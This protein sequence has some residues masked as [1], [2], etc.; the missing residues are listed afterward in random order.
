ML[1]PRVNGFPSLFL[2]LRKD[3]IQN[4][5]HHHPGHRYIHPQ[6]PGPPRNSLVPVESFPQG[7]AQRDE[8]QRH[9]H[10]SQDGVRPQMAR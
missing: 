1:P 5:I 10:D 4:H 2:L 6:R 3:L 8:N 7:V 9:D